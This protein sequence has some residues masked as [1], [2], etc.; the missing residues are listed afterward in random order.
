MDSSAIRQDAG[1]VTIRMARRDDME[2]IAAITARTFGPASI[3][4]K[5]EDML[6]GAPWIERPL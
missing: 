6:G 3:D 1:D 4:A 5:I 2:A